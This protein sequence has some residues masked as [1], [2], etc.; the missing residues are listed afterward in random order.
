MEAQPFNLL[1]VDDDETTAL[2]VR[3]LLGKL[4]PVRYALECAA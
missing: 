3:S 1:L 2:L 4:K